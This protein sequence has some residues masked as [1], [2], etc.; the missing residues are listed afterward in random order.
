MEKLRQITDSIHQTIYLSELESAMMS[1]AYFYRLHDVYQN[2]TVYL[3]FPCNRTKRYEHSCGTMELAGKMFFSAITNA[4]RSVQE[5][6]F[7]E[8]NSHVISIVYNLLQ[9]SIPTYCSRSK[10][11]I[12]NC[13]PTNH[14]AIELIVKRAYKNL[15]FIEDAALDHYMPPFFQGYK[16]KAD[17]GTKSDE[18]EV[19]AKHKFL[20]QCLLE[21]VRIVALFH[22]VGHPPYS[23]IMEQTLIDLY[24]QCKNSPD[25]FNP[26]RA[27]NLLTCLGPFLESPDDTDNRI[28]C[29]ISGSVQSDLKLHEQI[30]Q[31]MLSGA[32][33]DTLKYEFGKIK[34]EKNLDKKIALAV[35]Y[36]A[37]AEFCFAMLR[38]YNPFFASLHRIIDGC[39]DA[40]RMDY[41]ERDTHNSGV[42]WGAIPYKRLIESC[43]MVKK[44]DENKTF[45]LI[46]YPDKMS[47]HIDDLL[48]TRYKIFSRIN[49]HHRSYK[50]ALIL[51]RLVKFLAEDYLRKGY[52]K[53]GRKK[54]KKCEGDELCPDIVD[55]WNC[56]HRTL[57][58]KDLN[59][60]Q[61]NDST[62]I[63]HLYHTLAQIK[64]GSDAFKL[65]DED[66]KDVLNMLEEFLLNRKHFYS[67]FK[68]QSDLQ[69]IFNAV[70]EKIKSEVDEIYQYEYD[71]YI[72]ASADNDAEAAEDSLD[73][74][75]RITNLGDVIKSGDADAFQ[76]LF[77]IKPFDDII[78]DVLKEYND[79][80]QIGAYLFSQNVDRN[81]TGLPNNDDNS[82]KCD[83][84]YLYSLSCPQG[85]AYDT[86]TLLL[87][88]TQLQKDCLQYIAYVELKGKDEK[89]VIENIRKEISDKLYAHVEQ[90]MK[91]NFSCL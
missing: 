76:R 91:E 60:I 84:I 21:A 11:E 71:K 24:N 52:F 67:V 33:D 39:V 51:Q 78:L 13:F 85:E 58:S 41:I 81:H 36:I 9:D 28:S 37:V 7:E 73:S 35:Y 53:D 40:D 66:Y 68:R 32:F 82:S 61:W 86:T 19:T 79:K 20:Y 90:F 65:S 69:P 74:I 43:K 12:E 10:N 38:E 77:P 75:L 26:E 44:T 88:L 70:Y 23:H 16:E 42:D 80:D 49:Y 72:N 64:D 2:S 34:S 89:E 56:L 1:T 48:L 14:K 25:K 22:D 87:Q 50:T 29:L 18:T 83:L 31:T 15:K 8:A 46:A 6:F 62:L 59:I 5:S 45:Y 3:T 47:D 57:N 17:K 54:R 63:S 4:D 30:G 27:K 55:L